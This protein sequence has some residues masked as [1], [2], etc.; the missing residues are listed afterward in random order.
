M[1][2][3]Q[4]NADAA[5]AAGGGVNPVWLGTVKQDPLETESDYFDDS[6]VDGK[7][8][9]WDV[10]A[11]TTLS[12][13][14]QGLAISHTSGAG[15]Y[16]G[17][18]QAAPTDD[19]FAVT[20]R[21]RM[22]RAK[23]ANFVALGLIMGEDIITNPSTA[24]FFTIALTGDDG[25]IVEVVAQHWSDYNSFVAIDGNLTTGV[26][27]EVFLRWYIDRTAETALPLASD[28]GR[29]WWQLADAVSW[30]SGTVTS[31]DTIGLASNNG[32][33]GALLIGRSDMFRVDITSDPF[34][35]VGDFVTI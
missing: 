17:L 34:L 24:S 11:D 25:D 1:T 21:V 35:P 31:I 9:E 15:G 26:M 13:D 33:S 10:D 23:M 22:S 30:A 27:N 19:T 8:T 20:A 32:N 7:W 28:N 2:V 16:S 3:F 14:A 29:D 18:V 12:E 4:S 6:S 5:G